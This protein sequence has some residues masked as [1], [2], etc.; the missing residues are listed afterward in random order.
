MAL[1]R[2]NSPFQNLLDA[3]PYMCEHLFTH[4]IS[5]FLTFDDARQ[6]TNTNKKLRKCVL[7]SLAQPTKDGHRPTDTA[8]HLLRNM[9][10]QY[11]PSLLTRVLSPIKN[12]I[13]NITYS[14]NRWKRHYYNLPIDRQLPPS[15]PPEGTPPEI[16]QAV[17]SPAQ[18]SAFKAQLRNDLQKALPLAAAEGNAEIIK[19]CLSK[20]QYQLYRLTAVEILYRSCIIAIEKNHAKAAELLLD[21]LVLLINTY[22]IDYPETWLGSVIFAAVK[23]N[24]TDLVELLYTKLINLQK[25]KSFYPCSLQQIFYKNAYCSGN[26]RIV[27]HL[28]QIIPVT[29]TDL[30]IALQKGVSHVYFSVLFPLI[31]EQLNKHKIDN[32][33]SF[34]LNELLQITSTLTAPTLFAAHTIN[35]LFYFLLEL[36]VRIGS[37]PL[38]IKISANLPMSFFPFNSYLPRTL[39][40]SAFCGQEEILTYV[41]KNKG[42]WITQ[43]DIKDALLSAVRGRKINTFQILLNTPIAGGISKTDLD[44]CLVRSASDDLIADDL[45]MIKHL[46]K[47]KKHGGISPNAIKHFLTKILKNI[48]KKISR[49]LPNSPEY[50]ICLELLGHISQSDLDSIHKNTPKAHLL[51][52]I[53]HENLIIQQNHLRLRVPSSPA[54]RLMKTIPVQMNAL[55]KNLKKMMKS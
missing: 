26:E 10:I 25:I 32:A 13:L 42:R 40:L 11:S 45:K 7:D 30:L 19:I 29:L 20:A 18:Q 3:Y 52:P 17:F 53:I 28:K 41:L 23:Q 24:S 39:N 22:D 16:F 2:A 48:P 12:K 31:S 46:L 49:L 37:L 33:I 6:L 44:V 5:P 34:Y 27:S 4:H 51:T 1:S 38:F 43:N 50:K 35:A 9:N 21:K 47:I 8:K 55:I 36:T 54:W 15:E 14:E